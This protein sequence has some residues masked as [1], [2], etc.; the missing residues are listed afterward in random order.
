MNVKH[1]KIRITSS[2]RKSTMESR[3]GVEEDVVFDI[4]HTRVPIYF[5]NKDAALYSH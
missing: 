5:S 3:A 2:Q 4:S 1:Q